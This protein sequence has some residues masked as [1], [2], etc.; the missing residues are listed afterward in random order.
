MSETS[1]DASPSV[2]ADLIERT[3][4]DVGIPPCPYIL[5]RFITEM[6]QDDPDFN[7]LATLI[8][9]DV[10]LS[11]GLIKT[12]NSPYFG[13]RQ[14]VRSVN[15]ALAI[16][17]LRTAS[18]AVAGLILRD[19]FPNVPNLERFWDASA[20]IALLSGWLAQYFEIRGLRA[21]DAYTFGLFRDCGIPVLLGRFP[22]Y[23]QLLAKANQELERG[24]TEVEEDELPT[25]HA[26]VGCL[27]AQ[28]WWLP[29]EIC[30]AIRNHHDAEALVSEGSNLPQLSRRLIAV[31]QL[32]EYIV[33]RQ[34]GLSQT[35][36]WEKLGDGCMRVLTLD[37]VQLEKLYI[38]AE[39]IATS[40]D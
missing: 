26:M 10:G 39:P 24:F 5:D 13:V 23:G 38:E 28:N 32:A 7:R 33:Q 6:R 36:E 15:E 22:H 31:S 17:G 12:A 27:L 16:L 14:R 21:E 3:I 37:E 34:S 8:G 9:S 11:A 1:R 35:R 2:V 18:G 20:R 19:A 25:N 30:L 29:E 4:L 40:S